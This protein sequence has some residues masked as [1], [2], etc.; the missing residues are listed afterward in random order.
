MVMP[1]LLHEALMAVVEPVFAALL[2][3]AGVPSKLPAR[4]EDYVW[5]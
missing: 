3:L 5:Y 1:Y 4:N 2:R